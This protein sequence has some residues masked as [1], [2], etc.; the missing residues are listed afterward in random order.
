MSAI[1]DTSP[2]DEI[3]SSIEIAPLMIESGVESANDVPAMRTNESVNAIIF[4]SI[5]FTPLQN[6]YFEN[7]TAI[8]VLFA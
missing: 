7:Y 5:I 3:S 1:V 6:F 2:S 4:F 8:P